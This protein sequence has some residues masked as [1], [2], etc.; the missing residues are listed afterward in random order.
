[1]MWMASIIAASRSAWRAP[2]EK[3]APLWCRPLVFILYFVHPIARSWHRY[4]Y[5]FTRKRPSRQLDLPNYDPGYV[6]KVSQNL[7]DLDWK[8]ERGVGREEFLA[9]SVHR[10]RCGDWPGEYAPE[11]KPLDVEL[12]GD[13]WHKIQIHTA[14]E[15]LGGL[16]RF[17]RVRTRVRSTRLAV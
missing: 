14:T 3:G 2:L 12:V 4:I 17:T 1:G 5:R 16:K 11:W 6:K 15:E 8:S 13:H 9:A 7:F 10:A